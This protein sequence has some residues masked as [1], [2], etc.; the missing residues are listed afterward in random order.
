MKGREAEGEMEEIS[1]KEV[2]KEG[3]RVQAFEE[4]RRVMIHGPAGRCVCVC[5]CER[6][7]MCESVYV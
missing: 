6:V 3:E 4:E 2:Q 7:C 5:V 1:K